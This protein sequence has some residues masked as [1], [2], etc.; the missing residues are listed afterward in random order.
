MLRRL[1]IHV[2]EYRAC[3]N[4]LRLQGRLQHVRAMM[5]P[6]ATPLHL[7]NGLKSTVSPSVLELI[8]WK[9]H[10]TSLG[11]TSIESGPLCAC[12]E[13]PQTS[14]F[15]Q[16]KLTKIECVESATCGVRK[17]VFGQGS[18]QP[19]PTQRSSSLHSRQ[20]CVQGTASRRASEMG[21]LQTSHTP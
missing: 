9:Y 13:C 5:P 8:S 18:S 16:A 12:G 3:R 20:R 4:T 21:C 17:D 14:D 7:R 1:P 6:Q 19:R 15:G 11:W 10:M 2:W